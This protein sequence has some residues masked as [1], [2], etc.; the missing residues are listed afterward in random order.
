MWRNDKL[1]YS[2]CTGHYEYTKKGNREFHIVVVI[3][4][5]KVKTYKFK[6]WQAAIK[7][8]WRKS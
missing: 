5:T 1:E 6:S 8:G 2:N 4:S 7:A 3:P